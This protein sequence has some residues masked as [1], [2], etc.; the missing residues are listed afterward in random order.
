MPLSSKVSLLI[1]SGVL[2]AAAAASLTAATWPS[3]SSA[4]PAGQVS[5]ADLAI[6][7]QVQPGS[8]SGGLSVAAQAQQA[9]SVRGFKDAVAQRTRAIDLAAVAAT[10]AHKAHVAHLALLARQAA[11]AKAAAAQPSASSGSAS[12]SGSGATAAAQPVSTP[13]GSPQEVAQQMLDAA[14]LGG[15]FSCLDSLWSHE[16]GWSVYASNPGS[17]AYG[18]PQALPGSKM[19]SAGPGWQSSAATQIRWGLS[20]I[21]S[22]YGSPCGA[23]SHEEA[24]G[25]Y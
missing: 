2:C 4:A 16:S 17:G 19:A 25:W 9:D 22:T 3:G 6:A 5:M 1:G 7:G 15:Q 14:G 11:A 21:D 23:W 12:G 13:S 20:Y 10:A 24:S 18:I 8:L